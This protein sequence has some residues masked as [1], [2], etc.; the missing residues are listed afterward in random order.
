MANKFLKSSNSD[1]ELDN[2]WSVE[3][4]CEAVIYQKQGLDGLVIS[5]KG[6][7]GGNTISGPLLRTQ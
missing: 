2:A 7:G 3:K 6:E 4:D 5:A 1:W